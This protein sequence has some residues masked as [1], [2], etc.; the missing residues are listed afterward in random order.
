M[1]LEEDKTYSLRENI[2]GAEHEKCR[3]RCRFGEQEAEF[4]FDVMDAD[5]ICPFR[6]D[7]EDVWQGDAVE[8]LLSPNDGLS[9][10]YELEVS[11]F[12]VRFWGEVTFPDGQK[13][14]KKLP[15]SFEAKVSRTK[16]GYAV[17]IRLPLAVL[18]GFE[19]RTAK[20]NAFCLDRHADGR[21]DLYALNPTG[22]ATF[23][24]PEYFLQIWKKHC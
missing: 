24:K 7:N 11:P 1:T 12:G 20:M 6:E 22:C 21:Q 8:V 17:Q 5:L 23:H 16:D 3:F 18:N 19:R 9:R 2:T 13:K 15:P 10:Y 14:L 4:F